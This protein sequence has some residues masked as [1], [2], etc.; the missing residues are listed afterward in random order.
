MS[1]GRA[2]GEWRVVGGKAFKKKMYIRQK[3]T[4][5]GGIPSSF[6][7]P[8]LFCL[9]VCLFV[10]FFLSKVFLRGKTIDEEIVIFIL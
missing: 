6:S 2:E 7:Q 8:P 5:W 9:F 1:P 4:L 10:I 3:R